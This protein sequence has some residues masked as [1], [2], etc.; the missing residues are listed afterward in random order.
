MNEDNDPILL[1]ALYM[2]LFYFIFSVSEI[3]LIFLGIVQLVVSLLAGEP[4][5]KLQRFGAQFGEYVASIARYISMKSSIKPYPF[6]DWPEDP[7]TEQE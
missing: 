4:N 3:V 2:V 1:T 5:P 7:D 6:S